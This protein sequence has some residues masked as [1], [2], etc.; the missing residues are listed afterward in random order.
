MNN[1]NN[2]DDT[3]LSEVKKSQFSCPNCDAPLI[4]LPEKG[5]LHCNYCGTDVKIDGKNSIEEND[6]SE[7]IELDDVLLGEAKI[8]KCE[9][10]G[11][12]NKIKATDISLSCPFCGSNHVIETEE[13]YGIKPD[14]VIPFKIGDTAIKT[15]YSKWL[16]NKFFVPRKVKKQIPNSE[17]EGVYIPVWTFDAVTTSHY[18]GKLGKRYTRTVRSGGKTRTVTEIRYFNVN[19]VKN[20]NFDDVIVS[21]GVKVNQDEMA[22]LGNYDTNNALEYN[23][24]Y[25]AGFNSEHY[26]LKFKSGFEQAKSRMDVSIRANILAGYNHDVVSYLNVSTKYDSIKYKYVLV[27]VWIGEYSYNKKQYRFLG[28]GENGILTGKAPI[29]IWRVLFVVLLVLVIIIAFFW[30]ASGN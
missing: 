1:I 6:F 13:L 18:D 15:L 29:S 8:L 25:L 20:L 10:C 14:R 30:F 17:I 27:P 9:S 7:G 28:N 19:G 2:Y 23:M 3:S 26:T 5:M 21:A 11:A 4:Y 22:K 12:L 24:Q 16:K